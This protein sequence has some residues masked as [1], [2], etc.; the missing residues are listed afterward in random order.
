MICKTQWRTGTEFLPEDISPGEIHVWKI[1]DAPSGSFLTD[2]EQ[3]KMAGIK[4]ED[5]RIQYTRARSALRLLGA[6][7]TGKN[8]LDL[9]IDSEAHGKP[10]FPDAALHFNTSHCG[11]QMVIAFCRDCALGIDIENG[12]RVRNP[13]ALAK[14]FF[15]PGEFECLETLE[16]TMQRAAFLRY[17]VCKEAAL[18][19]SGHGLAGGLLQTT[20][21]WGDTPVIHRGVD[22]KQLPA[23][24]FTPEE[25]FYGAIV[26]ESAIPLKN[27]KWFVL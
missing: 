17:W 20:V 25:A 27:V 7:Y 22:Q 19:S 26:A 9:I 4:N 5:A 23:L 16:D 13:L 11:N 8:P 12:S 15:A 1:S 3:K 18:K 14:R 24:E 10:F 6:R 2:A 21:E